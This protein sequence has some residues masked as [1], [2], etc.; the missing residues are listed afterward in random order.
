MTLKKVTWSSYLSASPP[1]PYDVYFHVIEDSAV[2]AVLGAHRYLLA[3]CSP[4]FRTEFFGLLAEQE[5]VIHIRDTTAAAFLFL[6]R[7]IYTLAEPLAGDA[8]QLF[9]ILNLSERY[10]M[11]GLKEEARRGLERLAIH[12]ENVL[13]VARVAEAWQHF[14]AASTS[15]LLACSRVL[16]R[17]LVTEAAAAKVTEATVAELLQASALPADRVLLEELLGMEGGEE[18]E[19][20]GEAMQDLFN[21]PDRPAARP[22]SSPEGTLAS[23][24]WVALLGPAPTVPPDVC[25]R[26]T[27]TAGEAN[28]NQARVAGEVL[29]HKYLLAAASDTFRRWFF[30]IGEEARGKVEECKVDTE[31]CM[32]EMEEAVE[33]SDLRE[34]RRDKGIEIVQVVC[35][36]LGAFKVMVDY[37]Y[38]K[39]PTLRGAQQIC[40]IFEIIDLADRFGA[41]GLEE[42]YRTALFLYF[43]ERP[44]WSC[45][46]L[47]ATGD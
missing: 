28:N 23:V 7:Y 22:P 5:V 46:P 8:E 38:G 33:E 39:F 19:D 37:L 29:A 1:L 4:V 25:F 13:D 34:V 12:E 10:D 40:E 31:E 15:V 47:L 27:E 41:E 2:T 16:R 24:A 32:V 45:D 17:L 9:E 18:D 3:T 21:S 35:S 6:L 44:R 43:R 20:L 26:V 30:P 11:G 36:S 42:E 14:E